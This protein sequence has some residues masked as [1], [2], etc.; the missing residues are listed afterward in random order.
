LLVNKLLSELNNITGISF[1][2]IVT[3]NISEDYPI[4]INQEFPCFLITNEYPM[5]YGANHNQAFLHCESD[6]FVILNP[7]ISIGSLDMISLS[8]HFKANHVGIVS[9]KILNISGGIEDSTRPY[10]TLI[11][12]LFRIFGLENYKIPTEKTV[13][14]WVAGMFMLFRKDVYNELS[15]FDDNRFFMYFED[16]DICRRVNMNGYS[17]IYDPSQH[18]VHDAQR[19]SRKN[20]KHFIWHITSM[21]R[22]LSGL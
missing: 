14:D 3:S 12:L 5:G 8:S 13:V 17:I 10:P 7:D 2:V 20:L 6:F 4:N 21:F 22:Y 11:N 16:V 9:P 18:V 1:D 15:G 19:A